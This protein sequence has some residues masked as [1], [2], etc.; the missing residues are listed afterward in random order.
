M[1]LAGDWWS[2]V[3]PYNIDSIIQQ[4]S[5]Q[6]W[7]KYNGYLFLLHIKLILNLC[8]LHGTIYKYNK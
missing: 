6:I 1:E 5:A 7:T 8:T 2:A 4:Y 3:S